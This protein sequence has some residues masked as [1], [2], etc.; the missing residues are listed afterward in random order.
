[1]LVPASVLVMPGDLNKPSNQWDSR[2][3]EI[4]GRYDEYEYYIYEYEYS[5]R[6]GTVYPFFLSVWGNRRLAGHSVPY[7]Q[8]GM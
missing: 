7:L 2:M 4:R 8:Y 6:M 5:I 3:R 1:M